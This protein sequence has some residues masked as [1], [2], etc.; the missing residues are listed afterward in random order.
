MAFLTGS[1]AMLAEGIH[2]AVD[3]GN[4]ALLL[5][6]HARSKKAADHTHP[7]GYGREL[8]FWSLLV[9]VVIFGM[10]GGM[11]IVVGFDRVLSPRPLDDPLW[12]YVVLGIAFVLESVSFTVAYRDVRRGAGT[13]TTLSIVR[14]SKDPMTFT[15][16]LEDSAALVGL[17]IAFLGTFLGHVWGNVYLDGVASILIGVV[18]AAVA[19]FLVSETRSLLVGE[20]A[21]PEVVERI[22]AIAGAR[23]SVEVVRRALTMQLAPNEILLNLDVRFRAGLSGEAIVTAIGEIERDIQ[24]AIPDVTRIFIEADSLRPTSTTQPMR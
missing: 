23:P 8:Y 12:T 4:E 18:L 7:F 9:A 16:L 2:S 14:A 17:I 5:L 24:R 20:S 6:G 1:A 13:R 11:A 21:E 3:T 22:R 10:G 15:V 19:T